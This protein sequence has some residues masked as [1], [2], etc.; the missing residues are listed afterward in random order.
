MY[1]AKEHWGPALWNF[2]HNITIVDN[3][4]NFEDNKRVVK[5]LFNIY[6]VIP[7]PKCQGLYKEY[8][9][10]LKSLDLSKGM[11][12]FYWSIDLHNAVNKKLGKQ[13]WTYD[14]GLQHYAFFLPFMY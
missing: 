7:C 3:Q 4:S 8:L 11:V 13:P 1:R 14:Q 2:I 5:L 10:I 6:D 12:L 9:E